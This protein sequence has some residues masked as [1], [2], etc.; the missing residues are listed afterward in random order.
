MADPDRAAVSAPR[1]A[2][3]L[4]WLFT[5]LPL[6]A[7]FEAAARAGFD[8]VEFS[9]HRD[10]EPVALA[11]RLSDAGLALTNG[12][13]VLDWHRGVRGNA[14]VPGATE[15]FR[16]SAERS[17]EYASRCRMPTLHVPPGEVPEGVERARCLE[18]F[19]QNL[20]WIAERAAPLGIRIVFEPVCSARFPRF[21]LHTL[22]EGAALIGTTGRDDLGMVFD[23][24]HVHM[25]EGA[26]SRRFAQHRDRIAYVQI[27]NPPGRH[28]PGEG[29]LDLHWFVA[30]F[31]RAGY[32]GPIGL[33]Y[34][35]RRHTAAS[36][37]WAQRYG[38]RPR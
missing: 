5:E 26:A 2:P 24:F 8:A 13:A 22:D 29:E 20:A 15:A 3:N 32:D 21:L 35:P 19:A 31:G 36:L 9:P 17:L 37:G 38:V 25:E 4:R 10:I 33:E 18:T 30:L 23:T 12:L 11:R 16:D 27:G 14:G 7:R 28:E 34:V 1:F 6:E